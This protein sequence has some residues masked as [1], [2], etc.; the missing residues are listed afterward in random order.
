MCHDV[1]MDAESTVG[2]WALTGR[3]VGAAGKTSFDGVTVWFAYTP[4]GGGGERRE[5]M[6][7]EHGEFL[8][9]LPEQPLIRAA[10]GAEVEGA[11]P[12]DLEADGSVL[13]PGDVIIMVDDSL[14]AH[15]RY[16][17]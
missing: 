9:D 13:E 12:V 4:V 7:D 17:G 11:Q 2:E 6:A 5:T 3:L 10:V 8:F 15:L 1:G 16:A 14:P